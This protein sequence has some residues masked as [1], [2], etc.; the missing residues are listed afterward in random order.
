MPGKL[1]RYYSVRWTKSSVTIATS[2][3]DD[4][5][6]QYE[7]H[8]NFSLT[9]KDAQPSDSSANYQCSVTIN[10]PQI[11]GSNADQ[12]YDQLH[13]ITVMVYGKF[14]STGKTLGIWFFEE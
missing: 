10:D 1:S 13:S 14:S 6:P 7:L 9:I 11:P 8:D 3:S 2:T 12:V 4:V 5:L